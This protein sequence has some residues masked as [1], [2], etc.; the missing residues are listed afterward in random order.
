MSFP[1]ASSLNTRQMFEYIELL[2]LVIASS[3]SFLNLIPWNFS[4]NR[5]FQGLEGST[6][7]WRWWGAWCVVGPVCAWIASPFIWQPATFC[8]T[9]ESTKSILS[10]SKV[11]LRRWWALRQFRG[12]FILGAT[13]ILR[14]N[15]LNASFRVSCC[16]RQ[17]T[18]YSMY[19]AHFSFTYYV[20]TD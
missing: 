3:S 2:S 18:I 11:A 8:K 4:W 5:F 14:S 7:I 17:T 12:P 13:N 20:Y 19:V 9:L 15:F 1:T 16:A 6:M 10:L